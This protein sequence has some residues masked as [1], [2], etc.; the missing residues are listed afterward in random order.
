MYTHWPTFSQTSSRYF[1]PLPT[2]HSRAMGILTV[3][4]NEEKNGLSQ[5]WRAMW[6]SQWLGYYPMIVI[7][8]TINHGD[9]I[10]LVFI[11]PNG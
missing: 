3:T 2:L 1:F 4:V 11:I 9:M 10:W 6:L 7:N 8:P 5:W